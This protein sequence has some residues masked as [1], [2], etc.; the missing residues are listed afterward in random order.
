[1]IVRNEVGRRDAAQHT[2]LMSHLHQIRP[3]RRL[4]LANHFEGK[5]IHQLRL[6]RRP[7]WADS[8]RLS[9]TSGGHPDRHCK[10]LG[11]PTSNHDRPPA[12][13]QRDLLR[14]VR[15]GIGSQL[16]ETLRIAECGEFDAAIIDTF[17]NGHLWHPAEATLD[18]IRRQTGRRTDQMAAEVLRTRLHAHATTDSCP[19]LHSIAGDRKDPA[20]EDTNRPST[21]PSFTDRSRQSQEH[22]YDA[23]ASVKGGSAFDPEHRSRA[24]YSA[25]GSTSVSCANL[26]LVTR[27][28]LLQA[29]IFPSGSLK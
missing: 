13:C 14:I 4:D 24:T 29:H 5:W 25:F 7:I 3:S 2:D 16:G 27:R 20:L 23:S 10:T 28:P 22:R 6:A 11:E 17:H 19:A 26:R 18:V 1:M 8:R 15:S 12:R 21:E 9:E